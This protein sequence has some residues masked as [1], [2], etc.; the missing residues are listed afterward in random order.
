MSSSVL[1]AAV[2]M[3]LSSSAAYRIMKNESESSGNPGLI[4]GRD[5]R[6]CLLCAGND[7]DHGSKRWR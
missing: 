2:L 4:V 6:E 5:I 3:V 7:R 1:W